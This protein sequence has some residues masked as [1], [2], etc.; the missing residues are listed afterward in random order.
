VLLV[1]VLPQPL[2]LLESVDLIPDLIP[3]EHIFKNFKDCLSW[4]KQNVKDK[5]K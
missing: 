2:Y 3:R 1:D 5:F 4:I